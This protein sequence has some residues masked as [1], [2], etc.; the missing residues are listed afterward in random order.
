MEEGT[1]LGR[2]EEGWGGGGISVGI[3]VCWRRHYGAQSSVWIG[4]AREL[5]GRM[6]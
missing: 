3:G 4:L 5:W 6:L 1:G 2:C